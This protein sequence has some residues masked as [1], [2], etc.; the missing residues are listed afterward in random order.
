MMLVIDKSGSMGRKRSSSPRTPRKGAIELLGPSDKIGVIAF[1]GEPFMISELHPVRIKV[2]SLT[3]LRRSSA[4]GGTNMFPAMEAAFEGP[5]VG[6][7]QTQ[8]CRSF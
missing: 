8:A 4:G 6:C 1:D 2:S 5:A 3:G 7:L